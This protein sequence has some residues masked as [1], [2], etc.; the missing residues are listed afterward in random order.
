MLFRDLPITHGMVCPIGGSHGLLC[1]SGHAQLDLSILPPAFTETKVHTRSSFSTIRLGQPTFRIGHRWLDQSVDTE[2]VVIEGGLYISLKDFLSFK[3]PRDIL[4][5]KEHWKSIK[6]STRYQIDAQ[7]TNTHRAHPL[8]VAFPSQQGQVAEGH[9]EAS[10][11]EHG[12]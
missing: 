5:L 1:L 11:G 7:D 8:R 2:A 12:T 10:S 9:G 4:N 6:S 3:L